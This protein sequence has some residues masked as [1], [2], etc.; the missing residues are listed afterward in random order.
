MTTNWHFLDSE[1]QR[2]VPKWRKFPFCYLIKA[3][4]PGLLWN[5]IIAEALSA[6]SSSPVPSS[7]LQQS[8][9]KL[10]KITVWHDVYRI[11]SYDKTTSLQSF[12]YFV[13]FIL[14]SINPTIRLPY[15]LS[16]GRSNFQPLWSP[17]SRRGRGVDAGGA[18][19]CNWCVHTC[20][21]QENSFEPRYCVLKRSTC[22]NKHSRL[23]FYVKYAPFLS[24]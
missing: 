1:R 11:S 10:N 22:A 8:T 7:P 2:I 13:I 16:W 23:E 6:A 24:T 21:W 19:N 14:N 15:Y 3:L 4:F 9:L 18:L 20:V 5:Y 17:Q 12:E